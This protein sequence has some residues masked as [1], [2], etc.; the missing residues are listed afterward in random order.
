MRYD[1]LQPLLKDTVTNVNNEFGN[2]IEDI[3]LYG[4]YAR[5]DY[6][7][8]SDIDVALI[9]NL[10]RKE[11]ENYYSAAASIMSDLSL[12][13]DVFVSFSLIPSDEFNHYKESLPYYRNIVREGVELSA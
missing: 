3:I 9:M 1:D 2:I 11:L 5:G 7:E 13:H 10:P 4:S 12:E 8:E 6:T